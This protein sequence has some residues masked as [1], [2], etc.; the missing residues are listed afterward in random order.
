VSVFDLRSQLINFD[1]TDQAYAAQYVSVVLAQ[2]SY[3]PGI[4][5]KLRMRIR[6]IVAFESEA[7]SIN[8]D[9]RAR[10]VENVI[11]FGCY[12]CERCHTSTKFSYT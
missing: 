3:D 11:R 4:A 1:A 7:A 10:D 9:A 5:G 2:D 12:G 6:R 8:K